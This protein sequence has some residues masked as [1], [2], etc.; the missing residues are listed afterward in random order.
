MELNIQTN[1]VKFYKENIYREQW[2]QILEYFRTLSP[3]IHFYLV[4]QLDISRNNLPDLY[5]RLCE[6]KV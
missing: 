3:G 2:G 6:N 5:K 1:I 4:W